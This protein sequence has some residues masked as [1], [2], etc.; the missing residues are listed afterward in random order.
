MAWRKRFSSWRLA[1]QAMTG[2]T[3]SGAKASVS[4]TS[5]EMASPSPH[6]PYTAWA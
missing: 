3:T 4:H 1:G 5:G 2:T 6:Y